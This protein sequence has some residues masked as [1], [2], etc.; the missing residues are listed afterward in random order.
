MTDLL[1]LRGIAKH[2]GGIQALQGVSMSVP[3]G[4]LYGMIGP[5]G[6]GKTT[7]FNIITGF[8]RADDGNGLARLHLQGDAAQGGDSAI[9]H[10]QILHLQQTHASSPR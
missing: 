3:R 7:L 5:N 8:Y 1:Q 10:M 6:A 9:V 2:F 4:S